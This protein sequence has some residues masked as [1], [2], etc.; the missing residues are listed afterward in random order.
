MSCIR[1][2]ILRL[3]CPEITDREEEILVLVIRGYG[4]AAI[5]DRLSISENTVKTHVRHLFEKLHVDGRR[6]LIDEALS[7]KIDELK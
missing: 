5:A 6:R 4:N 7:L 1:A 2:N 3:R